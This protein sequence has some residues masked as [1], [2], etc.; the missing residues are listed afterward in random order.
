MSSDSSENDS[1]LESDLTKLI[2]G[3]ERANSFTAG[4]HTSRRDVYNLERAHGSETALRMSREELEN[5]DIDAL[6]SPIDTEPIKEEITVYIY[7]Y[8]LKQ[9]PII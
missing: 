8:K 1:T 7:I 2:A 6:L 5:T 4:G 9:E 3:I